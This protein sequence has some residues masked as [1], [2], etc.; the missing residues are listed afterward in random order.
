MPQPFEVWLVKMKLGR[1]RD[2]RP[3]IVIRKS[4]TSTFVVLPLSS[5]L[6][7]RSYRDFT[8]RPDDLDFKNTGL[9]R[10]S[11]AIENKEVELDLSEFV[12]KL[13]QL[14]GFTLTEFRDWYGL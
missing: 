6:N 2:P 5:A 12:A 14:N 13:G 11:F 1:S 3:A 9:D 7:L 8:I 10:E 4:G